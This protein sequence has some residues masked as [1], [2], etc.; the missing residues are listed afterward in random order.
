[1]PNKIRKLLS[2]NEAMA[3]AAYH[4]GCALGAGYPGTPSTEILEAFSTLGGYAEWAPNE[5]V[6]AEVA[7]GAAFG[8]SS[9]LVTMK[10]VGFNVA[11]DLFFTAS[12]SGVQGA[13]VIV[14]AD[15]PGMASSQNEQDTRSLAL[16]GGL[17]VLEPSD[18]QEAYDFVKLAFELSR[19]WSIPFVIRTTTRIAHSNTVVEF[20][21]E[22]AP[23]PQS[24]FTR[25]VASRVMVPGH[26]KPAHKRLRA[27]FSEMLDW[28]EKF[29]PN[30]AI[31]SS[32]K[33]LCI[34]SSGVAF[35]HALE[36]APGAAFFKVGFSNPL[37]V[38]KIAAFAADYE[39]CVVVEEGDPYMTTLL[40]AA[41]VKAEKRDEKWRF[42]ELN[43]DIVKA[44]IAGDLSYEMPVFKARPPQLCQSCP[45][46]FSFKPLVELGCIVAG[47]IGCYTLAAMKP[48]SGMDMQIC[49][50]A[51][52]GLGLGLRKVL[53]EE[54]ARKVVSVIGDST[55]FHSGIPG[56][57]EMVYNPPK[58]GHLVVVVDNSTTAMTGQQENPGTGRRLDRSPAKV[59]SIEAVAKAIGVDDVQVFNPVRDGE[60]IKKFI[61]EK[62]SG[63]GLALVVLR[64]PC[65][66]AAANLAKLKQGGR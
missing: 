48:I 17:P 47:D 25:D 20:N 12:Y 4:S 49:M 42:G 26:A 45:H 59:V 44:Q 65:I 9:A 23:L 2:G 56:L 28:N 3:L 22:A 11:Q 61:S 34:I 41:G 60:K 29:G 63:N 54:Q 37:P 31:E 16:A 13:L 27:K 35:Q 5:K 52:I 50:G 1:M 46:T 8:E 10:H 30:K 57:V 39:R 32:D 18:S 6:A 24:N 66:L 38:E 7:L 43:V 21:P 40:R 14:V 55:F 58:T 33:S 15:D 53:P 64:Q 51:S 62:L 19:K 36:A